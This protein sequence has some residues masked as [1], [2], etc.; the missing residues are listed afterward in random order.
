MKT[1]IHALKGI[2]DDRFKRYVSIALAIVAIVVMVAGSP[3]EGKTAPT[4]PG[5]AARG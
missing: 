2:W 5:G 1:L 4:A 3:F